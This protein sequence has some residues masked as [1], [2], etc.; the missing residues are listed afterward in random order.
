MKAIFNLFV[1]L[2]CT[3]VAIFESYNDPLMPLVIINSF[4]GGANVTV[5][6]LDNFHP[7]GKR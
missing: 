4:L 5:F 2:F 3:S 6:L 1:G 7:G